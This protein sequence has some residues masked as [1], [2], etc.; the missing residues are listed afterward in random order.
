MAAAA[1]EDVDR[2]EEHHERQLAPGAV[3]G[4]ALRIDPAKAFPKF[5]ARLFTLAPADHR[6]RPDLH[7][8][9]LTLDRYHSEKWHP[10]FLSHFLSEML[11][12]EDLK[13][14][15]G[16]AN[17]V[18]Y[19]GVIVEGDRIGGFVMHK[20]KVN[21]RDLCEAATAAGSLPPTRSLNVTQV[22]KDVRGALD[23]LHHL[24][25]GTNQDLV[26]CHNDV[27]PDSIML[28]VD[29]RAVLVD[30][31]S[32]RRKGKPKEKG[33]TIGWGDGKGR[34]TIDN[35]LVALGQVED[36]LRAAFATKL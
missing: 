6:D 4:S 36:Y 23:F 34:S 17:I 8:K 29:G 18:E 28:A 12:L 13:R 30:F 7:A 33:T 15:G 25:D 24:T 27:T 21:L 1:A 32:C 11:V 2:D 22:V 3:D 26:Y 14:V 10:L 19:C 35:D 31:D 9:Y 5:D 16:H 20:L